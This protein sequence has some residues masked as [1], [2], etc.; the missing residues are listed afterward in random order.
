MST[1]ANS[2]R[3]G[4]RFGVITDLHYADKPAS[5]E[6]RRFYR[7]SI[8]KLR[9]ALDAFRDAGVGFVIELGDLIDAGQTPQEE[10][11]YLKA[12]EA[13]YATAG[14]D[15]HYVLGNHCVEA[16]TKPVFRE[17]TATRDAPY[18][19][20]RGGVAFVV[21]DA[22]FDVLLEPY[23]GR[24]ADWSDAN[25]PPV[26]L[27]WLRETLASTG[28]PVVVFVHQRLDVSERHS[29]RNAAAVRAV[30]EDAGNVAAVFQGH[31]HR[32]DHQRINGVDYV[33]LDGAVEG[34]DAVADNAFAIVEVGADGA[35][36]VRGFGTQTSYELG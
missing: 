14:C 2:P 11:R 9:G 29:V 34:E 10:L 17:H 5:L 24:K 27:D 22:C 4:V 19:F 13:V 12:I 3:P 23:G 30:L 32:N 6:K 18:V 7:Q 1:A 33:T 35:V 26:Q 36:R 28:T 8:P 15:R 25:V 31:H 20:D 16:L 21:L